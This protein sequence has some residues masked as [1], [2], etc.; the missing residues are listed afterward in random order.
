L[1][2]NNLSVRLG[3]GVSIDV[4]PVSIDLDTGEMADGTRD[5]GLGVRYG[6]VL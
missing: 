2:R 5:T 1:Q 4:G 6:L 3:A